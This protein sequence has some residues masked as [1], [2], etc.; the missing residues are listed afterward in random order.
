[1]GAGVV[2]AVGAAGPPAVEMRTLPA[3]LGGSL[4]APVAAPP[5]AV[6][7]VMQTRGGENR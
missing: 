3:S 1:M 7:K 6:E 2:E 5:D 4:A